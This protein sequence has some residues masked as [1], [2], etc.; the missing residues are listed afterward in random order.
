MKFVHNI[1]VEMWK[2]GGNKQHKKRKCLINAATYSYFVWFKCFLAMKAFH[3][4]CLL[5]FSSLRDWIG[6]LGGYTID[7]GS[8]LWF[9]ENTILPRHL[10]NCDVTLQTKAPLTTTIE[11]K[12]VFCFSINKSDLFS[13]HDT[14]EVISN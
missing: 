5:L 11:P 12:D 7:G 13:K 2:C 8:C 10:F 6:F 1:D 3:A 9:I 14:N 4:L